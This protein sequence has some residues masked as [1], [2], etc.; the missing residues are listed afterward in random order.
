MV[1]ATSN[2]ILASSTSESE[3]NQTDQIKLIK[4]LKHIVNGLKQQNEELR[5]KCEYNGD[6]EKVF[7]YI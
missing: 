3:T 7:G 1:M 4:K 2:H 5:I 6:E